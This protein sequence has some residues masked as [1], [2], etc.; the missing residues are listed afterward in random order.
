M[1]GSEIQMEWKG[2]FH[3]FGGVIAILLFAHVRLLPWLYLHLNLKLWHAHDVYTHTQTRSHLGAHQTR[4][5]GKPGG[6]KKGES[7]MEQDFRIIRKF[8]F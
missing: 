2:G 6:R 3:F 7:E 8:R 1:E 4:K 5:K